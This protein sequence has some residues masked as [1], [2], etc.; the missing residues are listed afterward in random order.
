[1]GVSKLGLVI[2]QLLLR[3]GGVDFV[4]DLASKHCD[5]LLKTL[6]CFNM[7]ADQGLDTL[8][9]RGYLPSGYIVSS[10]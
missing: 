8:G 2:T 7:F 1:M 9:V 4:L 5:I 6:S 3:L 10:L